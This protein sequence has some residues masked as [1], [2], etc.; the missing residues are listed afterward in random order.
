MERSIEAIT[1]WMKKS[2]QKIDETKTEIAFYKHD[3]ATLHVIIG[4]EVIAT[5]D[6]INVLGVIFDT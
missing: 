1:K 2:V 6:S 3:V 4:G 5:K